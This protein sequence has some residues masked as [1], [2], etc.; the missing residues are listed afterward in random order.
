MS[1][2]EMHG[3][4]WQIENEMRKEDYEVVFALEVNSHSGIR[5]RC[6]IP[7]GAYVLEINF[8]GKVVTNDDGTNEI[9]QQ[10]IE[11]AELFFNMC[12]PNKETIAEHI[13]MNYAKNE[14]K[15]EWDRQLPNMLSDK[16]KGLF[17]KKFYTRCAQYYTKQSQDD[18]KMC[19][20]FTQRAEGNP[21]IAEEDIEDAHAYIR[22]AHAHARQAKYY[23]RLAQDCTGTLD[24]MNIA[25]FIAYFL[26]HPNDYW[27]DRKREKLNTRNLRV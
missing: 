16:G 3:L 18:R 15:E 19:L 20:I 11:K 12:R 25:K 8:N 9:P 1:G 13:K 17:S 26:E 6:K 4:W 21:E 5:V 23:K 27:K 24:K 14:D 22:D 7:E 10:V 2:I